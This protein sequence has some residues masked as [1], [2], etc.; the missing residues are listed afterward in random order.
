M[1]QSEEPIYA[2]SH[3][4]I[5]TLYIVMVTGTKR[6]KIMYNKKIV[7]RSYYMC[8]LGAQEMDRSTDEASN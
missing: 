3:V 6:K 2:L 4:H 5:H 1:W 8:M 7:A